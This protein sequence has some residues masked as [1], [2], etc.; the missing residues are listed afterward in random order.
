LTG[1]PRLAALCAQRDPTNPRR[2]RLEV[3]QDEDEW[4]EYH[5]VGDPVLHVDLAKRAVE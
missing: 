3:W 1:W 2:R 4:C 5:A